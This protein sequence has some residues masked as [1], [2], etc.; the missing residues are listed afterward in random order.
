MSV[1]FRASW[2]RAQFLTWDEFISSPL[3]PYV[4]QWESSADNA[5]PVGPLASFQQVCDDYR[6]QPRQSAGDMK[7][8][9]ELTD[10]LQ[11][12]QSLETL[13]IPSENA[14]F[15]NLTAHD[16]PR[17]KVLS[18]RGE[19]QRM[20]TPLLSVFQRM[21][22]LRELTVETACSYNTGRTLFCPP[23]WTGPYPWPEMTSLV[24]SYP[25]PDDALYALLPP[26]LQRL[27][28]H[29]WPR[30]YTTLVPHESHYIAD[31]GW[32]SP[33]LSSSEMLQILSQC[34]QSDLEELELEF[35]EDGRDLELFS[36]IPRV[37]PNLVKL[38]ILRYRKWG[39]PEV[40]V[41]E[42]GKAL[43]PL[44]HLLAIY[45]HLDFKVAPHPY[46]AYNDTAVE[47]FGKLRVAAQNA[48]DILALEL[49]SSVNTIY[50]LHRRLSRNFWVPFGVTRTSGAVH[51]SD[52][53]FS[54]ITS[55]TD[56]RWIFG[57]QRSTVDIGK[58][59]DDGDRLRE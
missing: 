7:L 47:E 21:P 27:S 29:C 41:R 24:V 17:L 56:N 49:S 38:T 57:S 20:A 52:L 6:R 8:L 53:E 26:T 54:T 13:I 33:V 23:G 11:L 3:W 12:Q 36:L 18:L 39:N 42:I 43:A 1:L 15:D 48:A 46:A 22:A 58:D 10:H 2:C 25:H 40:P 35:G 32:F 59:K 50:L 28:L 9:R 34:P 19:M 14:P 51:A 30:H 5:L 55:M 31:L 45:L 44:S 37:F 4:R 16:W